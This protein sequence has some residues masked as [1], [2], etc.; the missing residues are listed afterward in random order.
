MSTTAEKSAPVKGTKATLRKGMRVTPDPEF[1]SLPAASLGRTF[2][3]DRV[4]AVNTKTTAEDG[5]RGTAYPHEAYIILADGQTP[6]DV[7]PEA[8]ASTEFV[9]FALGQIVT[10]TQAW[11]GWTTETPLIVLND[12]GDDKVR[13]ALLG[14]EGDRYARLSRKSLVKRDLAWL[15]E[16]LVDAA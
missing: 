3:V 16:A 10:V 7:A 12:T 4:N 5:G 11:K 14:G 1:P 2:I 15:T 13:V 8:E 9:W 6:D